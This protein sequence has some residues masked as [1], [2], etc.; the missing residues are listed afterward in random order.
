MDQELKNI[1]SNLQKQLAECT[2]DEDKKEIN[3]CM[4]ELCIGF[5]MYFMMSSEYKDILNNVDV[6]RK[7]YSSMSDFNERKEYYTV[8]LKEEKN[9]TRQI[10]LD[11]LSD[12]G[13]SPLEQKRVIIKA[14]ILPYCIPGVGLN[15]QESRNKWKNDFNKFAEEHIKEKMNDWDNFLTL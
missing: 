3:E 11:K 4:E 6:K 5:V 9:K 8:L 13:L 2:N 15:T 7:E 1:I 14:M 12:M 10:L